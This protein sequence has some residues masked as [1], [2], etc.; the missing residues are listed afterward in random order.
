MSKLVQIAVFGACAAM[1]GC[2]STVTDVNSIG[3]GVYMVGGTGGTGVWSGNEVKA[4]LI[5]TAS[6]DCQKQGKEFQLISDTAEDGS[7]YKSASAEIK[8]RCVTQS[9]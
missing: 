7:T 3:G 1:A 6:G 4:G 8:F 9:K 5:K 2:A